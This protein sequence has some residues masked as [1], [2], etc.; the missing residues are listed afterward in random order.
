MPFVKVNENVAYVFVAAPVGFFFAWLAR[1]I[2]RCIEF[3]FG[4]AGRWQPGEWRDLGRLCLCLPVFELR[5]H[6]VVQFAALI[7]TLILRIRHMLQKK[8]N[9]G[10]PACLR[11]SVGPS[12]IPLSLQPPHFGN[13]APFD[14]L[15]VRHHRRCGGRLRLPDGSQ[16]VAPRPHAGCLQY[17]REQVKINLYVSINFS[18]DQAAFAGLV[19]GRHSTVR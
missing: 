6:T 1:K 4:R 14:S 16:G 10:V 13:G 15:R 2:E 18:S 5:E 8:I 11:Q 3:F 19:L 7:I 12:A 17:L 9:Q